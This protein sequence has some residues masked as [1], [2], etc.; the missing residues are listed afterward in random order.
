[1]YVVNQ[2]WGSLF[3]EKNEDAMTTVFAK[4][5]IAGVA[6]LISKRLFPKDKMV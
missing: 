4:N 1:M 5:D 6:C 2:K 3:N